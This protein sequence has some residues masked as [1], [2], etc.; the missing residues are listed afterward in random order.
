MDPLSSTLPP[1]DVFAGL[2]SARVEDRDAATRMAILMGTAVAQKLLLWDSVPPSN[3]AR[4]LWTFLGIHLRRAEDAAR[5]PRVFDLR[6]AGT[7]RSLLDELARRAGVLVARELPVE[8]TAA[9]EID[10]ARTTLLGA[11]DAGCAQARCR[12]G[13]RARGELVIHAEPEPAYPTAYS[14]PMRIRMIE[15]QSV[16]ATDFTTSS[17]RIQVRLRVEWEWPITPLSPLAIQ[18]HGQDRQYEVTAV[19]NLVNVGM[20]AEVAVDVGV[21]PSQ[22]LA[23]SG[24]V[25]S[26]FEGAYDEI[27]LAIG[28]AVTSHGVT[29]TALDDGSGCQ[30]TIETEP[31]RVRADITDVGVSPMIL[32]ITKDGEEGI[33]QVHRVRVAGASGAER[34]GL[35]FRDDF[36]TIAELRLRISAPPVRATF[37]FSLPATPLP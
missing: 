25:T 5:S 17:A 29:V 12:G 24:T 18:I 21:D 37:P 7:M 1:G 27:R 2:A 31:S 20:V 33:P 15:I 28:A 30:I 22:M 34:W 10:L 6:H 8:A 13:Q 19:N 16:R 26:L 23:L 4:R 36:G 35:R 32:A 14:G 9:V 3:R 11:I